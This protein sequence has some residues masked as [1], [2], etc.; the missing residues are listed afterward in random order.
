MHDEVLRT[1][2]GRAGSPAGGRDFSIEAHRSVCQV[3]LRSLASNSLTRDARIRFELLAIV[4]LMLRSSISQ[5]GAHL[6]N[7]N[8]PLYSGELL[9]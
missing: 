8:R 1:P 5:G 3:S 9:S 6:K 4:Q 2:Q 7:G